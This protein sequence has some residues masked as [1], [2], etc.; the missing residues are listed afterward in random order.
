MSSRLKNLNQTVLMIYFNFAAPAKFLNHSVE[1]RRLQQNLNCILCSITGKEV[2]NEHLSSLSN[3][4]DILVA[5][6][7]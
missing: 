4:Q 3:S 6:H 5:L 1:S 2:D 7:P